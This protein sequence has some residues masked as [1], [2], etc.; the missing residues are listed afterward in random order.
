MPQ[1]RAI[2]VR[3]CVNESR[4]QDHALAVDLNSAWTYAPQLCDATVGNRQIP[5][6][7]RPATAINQINVAENN[8]VQATS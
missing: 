5:L 4:C 7:S 3:V 8:I 6:L 2:I 1:K